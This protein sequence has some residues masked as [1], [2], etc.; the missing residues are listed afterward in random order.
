MELDKGRITLRGTNGVERLIPVDSEGYFYV[1]WCMTIGR[2]ELTQEPFEGVLAQYQ[3]RLPGNANPLV[4][5]LSKRWD[6]KKVDWHNKLVVVGSSAVGNDLTD[7]GATPL[8][9]NTLLVSKH[10]NVANSIMTGQF[11]RRSS[12]P[13]E[14]A[15]IIVMGAAAAYLTWTSRSYRALIWILMGAVAYVCVATFVYIQFRYW[16]PI[17]V[18]VAGGHI[19]TYVMLMAYIVIFEQAERRRMRSVFTKMVPPDVVAELEESGTEKLSLDGARRLVTVLFADI[20][21]FTEMTDINRE[22][23]T[24]YIVEH[25]L[26]GSEAEAVYDMQA[27]EALDTVNL[28]SQG[29]CRSRAEEQGNGGQIHRRLRDGVLGCTDR[30]PEARFGLCSGGH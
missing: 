23:A 24:E 17:V 10:W 18:P 11:I 4:E 3:G 29:H 27:R 9:E 12:L 16:M 1:N 14:L 21:G 30:K 26:T 2:N 28:L 19:V 6:N 7:R 25:K 20:R 5:I 15:L 8:S 13:T 22:K